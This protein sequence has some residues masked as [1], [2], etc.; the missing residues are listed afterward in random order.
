MP[1]KSE[2]SLYTLRFFQD[3]NFEKKNLFLTKNISART[4]V[5]LVRIV[6]K[7]VTFQTAIVIPFFISCT[8]AR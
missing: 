8:Y 1:S 7:R 5:R 4:T 6:M 3:P 2:F